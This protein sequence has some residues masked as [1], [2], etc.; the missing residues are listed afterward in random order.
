MANLL[1]ILGVLFLALAVILPLAQRFSKPVEPDE[2]Q[3]YQKII[4]F[5]MAA[6]VIALAIRFFMDNQ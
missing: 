5:L 4:G 3:K 1:I 2:A 6:M